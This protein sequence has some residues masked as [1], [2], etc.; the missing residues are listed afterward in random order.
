MFC[1]KCGNIVPNDSLYCCKCG[2]MIGN[3]ENG[4]NLSID[5]P[6]TMLCPHCGGIMYK[7][8]DTC[9]HCHGP[10][11]SEELQ[12][13]R[14][15][16]S[17]ENLANLDKEW[18]R[19]CEKHNKIE[20]KRFRRSIILGLILG[21]IFV[22]TGVYLFPDD[23]LNPIFIAGGLYFFPAWI[24]GAYSFRS[25]TEWAGGLLL[26]PVVGWIIILILIFY[27]P[28][29]IG[30]LF[31]FP[32]SIIRSILRKPLLSEKEIRRLQKKGL[33]PDEE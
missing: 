22:A 32:R 27:V 28:P 3:S 19:F 23:F 18:K 17:K 26:F 13:K 20:K 31:F 8:L 29:I 21:A 14:E 11:L 9:P 25:F 2:S 7:L 24:Y 16:D 10:V 15:Q 6:D 12:K 33:L 30:V 5:S 1:P 4:T